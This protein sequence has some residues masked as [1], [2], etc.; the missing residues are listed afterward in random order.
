MSWI[1]PFLQWLSENNANFWHWTLLFCVWCQIACNYFML[2]RIGLLE[3]YSNSLFFRVF[4]LETSLQQTRETFID[5]AGR[6]ETNIERHTKF[7]FDERTGDVLEVP[8]ILNRPE[9][10]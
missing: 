7:V 5:E 3:D 4:K 2:R 9:A 6:V 10:K 1:E 8:D